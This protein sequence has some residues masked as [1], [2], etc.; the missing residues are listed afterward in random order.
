MH[1]LMKRSDELK[2]L[3]YD[4]STISYWMLQKFYFALAQEPIKYVIFYEK[5]KFTS[6][7]GDLTNR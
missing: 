5:I 4:C 3:Q 7:G 6:I 2:L 1:L